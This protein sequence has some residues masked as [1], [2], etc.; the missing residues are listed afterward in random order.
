MI[1]KKV[2]ISHLGNA[3]NWWLR[4]LNFY[5][6]EIT[7]LKGILTEIAGKNTGAEV[8]KEV[9][10]FENQFKIQNANID[11][12]THDIHV[13]LSAISKEAQASSAGYVDNTLVSA[14]D[15]LGAKVKDEEKVLTDMVHEFRRF[16]ESWM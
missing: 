15:A 2:S 8:M 10:H 11:R 7:I 14:H 5:K 1:M 13:N 9:E 12:L 6:T 4:S 16:A 3:H